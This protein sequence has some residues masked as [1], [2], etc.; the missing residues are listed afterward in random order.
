MVLARGRE[1]IGAGF[2]LLVLFILLLFKLYLPPL[3]PP[4]FL[5]LLLGLSSFNKAL[6]NYL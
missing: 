5:F 1:C 6:D 2:L 4:L 3:P